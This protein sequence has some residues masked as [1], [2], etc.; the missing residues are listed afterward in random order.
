[1]KKCIL[2]RLRQRKEP[3]DASSLLYRSIRNWYLYFSSNVSYCFLHPDYTF[4][5]AKLITCILKIA[6]SRDYILCSW[7]YLLQQ[8]QQLICQQLLQDYLLH[9]QY[10]SKL[11]LQIKCNLYLVQAA[12]HLLEVLPTLMVHHM[13]PLKQYL[14]H[15]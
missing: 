13:L 9:L 11:N 4:P 6:K 7:L 3:K 1:M 5:F 2:I 8:H 10:S 14:Y 15:Q 12:Q